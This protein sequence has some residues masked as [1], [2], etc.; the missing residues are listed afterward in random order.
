MTDGFTFE[1]MNIISDSW[2]E[3]FDMLKKIKMRSAAV[4]RIPHWEQIITNKGENRFIFTLKNRIQPRTLRDVNVTSAGFLLGLV[5]EPVHSCETERSPEVLNREILTAQLQTC[6]RSI[7]AEYL[8]S[9]RISEEFFF[10]FFCIFS[11]SRENVSQ[12]KQTVSCCSWVRDPPCTQPPGF[13]SVVFVSFWTHESRTLCSARKRLITE[14]THHS[15]TS[16]Q[17]LC[18]SSAQTE[19][20]HYMWRKCFCLFL[21]LKAC[22]AV[23]LHFFTHLVIIYTLL[24]LIDTVTISILGFLVTNKVIF[25]FVVQSEHLWSDSE[26]LR[27]YLRPELLDYLAMQF[28]FLLCVDMSQSAV[29]LLAEFVLNQSVSFIFNVLRCKIFAP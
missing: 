5:S 27:S 17:S 11:F 14:W 10:G 4:W 1:Q 16:A 18:C 22:T 9:K 13:H 20:L 19:G 28:L 6:R 25:D 2:Y 15:E 29:M 3:K 21:D 26:R 7:T 24:M 12:Q 23:K 8:S